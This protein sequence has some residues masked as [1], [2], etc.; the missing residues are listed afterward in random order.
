VFARIEED[1]TRL[2]QDLLDRQKV[3]GT[4]AEASARCTGSACQIKAVN[5]S[6][7]LQVTRRIKNPAHG[8]RRVFRVANLTQSLRRLLMNI[9]GHGPLSTPQQPLSFR[10]A[11]R[12]SCPF[13]A[14]AAGPSNGE[15]G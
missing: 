1:D 12:S 2:L 15:V 14:I 6:V 3:R 4:P 11:N 8:S 13:S 5:I 7:P 9:D 10:G